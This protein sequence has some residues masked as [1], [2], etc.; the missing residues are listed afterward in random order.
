M[1][2]NDNKADNKNVSCGIVALPHLPIDTTNKRNMLFFSLLT[3]E[4]SHIGRS[5]VNS[6][7]V[8]TLSAGPV[9]RIV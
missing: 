7:P 9:P 6:N 1:T 5:T 4:G 8:M 3:H 2:G